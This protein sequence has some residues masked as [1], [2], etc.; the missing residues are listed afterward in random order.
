[1]K[2]LI[3]AYACAP[4]GSECGVGWNLVEQIAKKHECWVMVNSFYKK[5]IEKA[6]DESPL[7]NVNFVYI[8]VDK[9]NGLKHYLFYILWQIKAYFVAKKLI[10]EI[11][12]D[13]VHHVTYQNSWLPTFMGLLGL[14]FIYDSSYLQQPPWPISREAMSFKAFLEEIIR[15]I[16]IKIFRFFSYFYVVS[17]SS[18]ILT[19]YNY[20][21]KE[22]PA[23][24]FY[25]IGLSEADLQQ[26]GNLP[27]KQE[28][29]F[30]VISIGR[31]IGWKGFSFSIKAFAKFHQQFPHSE[32]WIVGSGDEREALEKLVI[33]NGCEDCIKFLGQIPRPE[34]LKTLSQVD[35]MILPSLHDLFSTVVLESMAASK[36]V[37]ALDI[38]GPSLLVKDDCGIKVPVENVDQI[39][40]DLTSALLELA[41]NEE[42]RIMMSKESHHWVNNNWSWNI[43]GEKLDILYQELTEKIHKKA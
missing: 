35:C 6:L 23:K 18:L 10:T 39:I 31:L 41:N 27:P 43:I 24:V 15:D 36:P 11:D 37:I 34:V 22:L 42:K 17:R 28:K 20:L 13:L 25:C 19:N 7:D 12:F 8:D 1:M 4:I 38:N 2:I 26:L 30:R 29:T 14:P 32:Y 16:V 5:Y 40:D 9:P 21:P 3:S 33:E